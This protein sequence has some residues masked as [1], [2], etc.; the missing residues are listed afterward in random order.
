MRHVNDIKLDNATVCL[1]D[2]TGI[3]VANRASIY[4]AVEGVFGAMLREL[5]AARAGAPGGG[6]RA[7]APPSGATPKKKTRRAAKVEEPSDDDDDGPAPHR[8]GHR[9]ANDGGCVV[10]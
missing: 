4:K 3:G 9:P 6:P 10:A 1:A 5:A 2:G 8:G 7:A